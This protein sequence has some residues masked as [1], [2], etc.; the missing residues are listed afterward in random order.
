[1][2]LLMNKSA[3]VPRAVARASPA[4]RCVRSVRVQAT[5]EQAPEAA[6]GTVFYGGK[7][8]TESEVRL[9]GPRCMF[10]LLGCPPPPGP[11]QCTDR[12]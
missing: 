8:Y 12:V 4:K 2:A 3:L 11:A 10:A 9:L 6:P 5:E 1:M 7:S